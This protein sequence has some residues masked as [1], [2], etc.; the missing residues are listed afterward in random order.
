MVPGQIAPIQNH[1][2]IKQKIIIQNVVIIIIT[3]IIGFE[4]DILIR[5]N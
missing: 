3:I 1:P 5:D 2:N 4:N